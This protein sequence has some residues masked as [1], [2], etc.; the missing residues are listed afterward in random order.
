ES[1]VSP[2]GS[3]LSSGQGD[4][5]VE[6]RAGRDRPL[7][8]RSGVL[9]MT[10]GGD[11]GRDLVGEVPDGGAGRWGEGEHRGIDRIE[12]DGCEAGLDGGGGT[13]SR[14]DRDVEGQARL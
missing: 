1:L 10:G 13:A 7:F 6:T 2:G 9:V 4:G 3:G 14:G 8:A 12:G 11:S 5:C